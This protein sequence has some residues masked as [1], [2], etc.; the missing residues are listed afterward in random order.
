MY[1]FS[2]SGDF[3]VGRKRIATVVRV[4]VEEW[5]YND[6]PARFMRILT[7]ENGKVVSIR[8]GNYGF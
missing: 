8:K 5:V 3:S 7:L 1:P 6:G 2:N 4:T